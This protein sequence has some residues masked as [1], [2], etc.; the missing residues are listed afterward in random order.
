MPSSEAK[1]RG[2][3]VVLYLD[4]HTHSFVEEFSTSNFV[5]VRRD[6]TYVTPASA[7]ILGSVTNMALQRVAAGE[8]GLRVEV[9]PV[10]FT[11]VASFTEVAACGT[12][13]VL[14]PIRRFVC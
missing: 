9:R 7:S 10:P 14:N 11:E 8:C 4:A 13:V 5:G 6:G 2:F 3:P 1:A 12:A